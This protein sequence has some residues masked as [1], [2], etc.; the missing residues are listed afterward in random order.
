MTDRVVSVA[1][2]AGRASNLACSRLGANG[3]GTMQLRPYGNRT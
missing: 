1:S 3:G 2:F